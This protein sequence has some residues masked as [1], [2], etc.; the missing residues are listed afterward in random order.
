ML[1]C[2]PMVLS[3][4]YMGEIKK[5]LVTFRLPLLTAISKRA[6]VLPILLESCFANL[7]ENNRFNGCVH[8]ECH[9]STDMNCYD[10]LRSCHRPTAFKCAGCFAYGG[11]IEYFLSVPTRRKNASTNSKFLLLVSI[12]FTFLSH[13]LQVF[14]LVSFLFSLGEDWGWHMHVVRPRPL[15]RSHGRLV[16][17]LNSS[18][19]LNVV[20]S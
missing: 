8:R 19:F 7:F 6:I 2:S 12:L 3:F 13:T 9:N 20:W 14:V 5:C 15:F 4:F 17:S 16:K 10:C 1:F 11:N 18:D